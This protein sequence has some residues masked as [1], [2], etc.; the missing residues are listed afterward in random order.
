MF[1]IHVDLRNLPILNVL[2]AATI[3]A[4]RQRVISIIEGHPPITGSAFISPDSRFFSNVISHFSFSPFGAASVLVGTFVDAA[5]FKTCSYLEANRPVFIPVLSSIPII[6]FVLIFR[7]ATHC[8]DSMVTVIQAVFVS[9][10]GRV[11]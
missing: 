4:G 5:C 6:R 8:S 3:A 7:I 2:S 11:P 1:G 9:R 10:L